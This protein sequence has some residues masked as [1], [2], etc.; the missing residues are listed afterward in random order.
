MVRTEDY[1]PLSDAAKRLG[2]SDRLVRRW[3]SEGKLS[4]HKVGRDWLV[5]KE[6]E[7]E[8]RWRR[9]LARD[10]GVHGKDDS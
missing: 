7:P 5:E 1:E 9:K 4:C 10:E 3:C 6:A 8:L 2:V